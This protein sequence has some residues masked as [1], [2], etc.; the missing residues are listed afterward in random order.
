MRG[1][2]L[3]KAIY[4]SNYHIKKTL[5][6]SSVLY[7][8]LIVIL[9]YFND[10]FDKIKFIIS[11]V[12]ELISIVCVFK[13]SRPAIKRENNIEELIDPGTSLSGKGVPSL[14]FDILAVS[15][16]IKFMIF[17]SYAWAILYI[18]IGGLIFYEL[19]YKTIQKL[20]TN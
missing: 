20:K 6:A 10:R 18:S 11:S 16:I 5:L 14:L 19:V 4:N 13:I 1:S 15:M 12:P 3:N 7:N 9:F 17:Y 8:I 2:D